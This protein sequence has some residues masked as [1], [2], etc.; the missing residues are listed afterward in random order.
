MRC[1]RLFLL[2]FLL[3]ASGLAVSCSKNKEHGMMKNMKVQPG[4]EDDVRPKSAMAG[5]RQMPPEPKG[6]AA[7]P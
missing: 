4:Y 1:V 5:K 7:P 3:V 6:P 2:A